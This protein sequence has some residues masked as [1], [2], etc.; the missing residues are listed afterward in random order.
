[1]RK[2]Y[3]ILLLMLFVG[4]GGGISHAQIKQIGSPYTKTYS[5]K[6]FPANNQN[7]S[8]TNDTSGVMYFGNTNGILEFD[9]IK[10][11]LTQTPKKSAI[12]A[13]SIDGKNNTLYVG[14]ANDF[15]Y[16]K[17]ESNGA[18]HYISLIDSTFKNYNPNISSVT[19]SES[20]G[21]IFE[22]PEVLYV[23]K[24][25]SVKEI[26]L[27]ENQLEGIKKGT[28]FKGV[29]KVG[30]DVLVNHTGIGIM[31]LKNGVLSVNH[32]FH[33]AGTDIYSVLK[34]ADS[35]VVVN[36]EEGIFTSRYG[37]CE[38]LEI[39]LNKLITKDVY[40]VLR[41]H[42]GSFAFG[43]ISKGVIITD[44]N[45]RVVKT[46]LL[47]KMQIYS[48]YEDS[49]N[50][51][52]VA[53]NSGICILDLYSPFSKF[54]NV[55]T[56]IAGT[57]RSAI[58]KDG[59]IYLG[60]DAVY[61]CDA[62]S[63]NNPKFKELK[64]PN[65]RSA[66]WCLDTLGG[67]ILGGTN[68]GLITIKDQ[69]LSPVD[70]DRNIFNFAPSKNDPS[71]L[72]AVG[73]NGFSVYENKNGSWSYR[74][75]VEGFNIKVRSIDTDRQG[76][77]WVS[78]KSNGVYKINFN[79]NYNY[80]REVNNYSTENG[81]PSEI[82]NYLF[83]TGKELVMGTPDGFYKYDSDSDKFFRYSKLNAAFEEKGGYEM[84]YVD[85][86]GNIWIKRVVS[87]RK[88]PNLQHWLLER[89]TL[90][91]D[92]TA[93][94]QS[95]RFM[96]YMDKIYSVASIG[97]GCYI[98]GN[99]D[100]FIHYD[101]RIKKDF[102]KP[103]KAL[104]RGIENIYNDSVIVGANYGGQV[105]SLP[106]SDRSIRIEFAA[107]SYEYP[108]FLRFKTFLENNDDDW[109]DFK[110]ETKKEYSNL[111]PGT[112]VFH[113]VA[114][115]CYSEESREAVI[116]IRI[117]APWYLTIW[118]IVFYVLLLALV[119]WLI[120]KAYTKKLI[121]DKHKLEQ[122][123]EERTSEIRK[124]SKLIMEK[125][126]EIIEK[127]KSIT[128]S[129]EYAL[130]IQ[131]AM[132]PLKDKIDNALPV[133]FILYRPKDI[134]SGDYYWFA[135]TDKKIII[136]AADCTGHGVPGAFMSMIGSQILTEIVTD[137]ITSADEILTNQNFRIRKALKQD[138]TDNHDG[139]DMALCS[140]D[141][142]THL[143]EYSGAKNPLIYIQNGEIT[144]IKADKQ[145]IGGDQIEENF[146][147]TKHEIQPD[148]NTWFYMFSDGYEDQFGGPDGKKFKIKNLRELIFKIHDE[149]PEKQR[150]ILN[151]TIEDWIGK[152]GEQTDD[153]I[154]MGFKL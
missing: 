71:L 117:L 123:V 139:M 30:E 4:L 75:G 61:V 17:H 149:P 56:G 116:T 112:Y 59:K 88:D 45:L 91:S 153:I 40:T 146:H 50:L 138:T 7:W 57:I 127:N 126:E 122:I 67:V 83:N 97:N 82:G 27:S 114:I 64:N 81:L 142:E 92:T 133:N 51:L 145:G 25:D 119:V 151:Q 107:S 10:W 46:G 108:E 131:R 94:C 70:K 79:E 31:T 43:T 128:D 58:E 103:Y 135:E 115:N 121:R 134:V 141:K 90:T 154:L 68:T 6:D 113:V 85:S 95:G 144:T 100:G 86:R 106:Y 60:T 14:A 33:E 111:W 80:V 54:D 150:E 143:V 96:P 15:G 18:V 101:E 66:V 34:V 19:V 24:D 13:L 98:I 136:T 102:S 109:T 87:S 77:F 140:I 147:Y 28:K 29:F 53:G 73:G 104:I 118:A 12:R 8:I 9:G 21:V 62:D 110:A 124:Q 137:G 129:I 63:L 78:E 22:S 125:N 2:F 48:L 148:G 39:P 99:Q 105:V 32:A 26:K 76:N 89:Y 23:L 37:K 130:H 3:I 72:V 5:S 11:T 84:M 16:L 120:I 55:S 74:N 132:L 47:P 93:E 152:D 69:K 36:R 52:W 44:K 41:L 49:G 20:E 65:G 1:M 35:F 38:K 42:D